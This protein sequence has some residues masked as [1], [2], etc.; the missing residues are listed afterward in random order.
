MRRWF[1]AQPQYVLCAAL[2]A[3]P[4]TAAASAPCAVGT[5]QALGLPQTTILVVQSLAAGPNASPVGTIAAPI[6][7]VRAV[8][9]DFGRPGLGDFF[10]VWLPTSTWNGKY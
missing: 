10:E 1:A 4:A 6:C 5:F 8:F 7:R 3:L 9:D 2:T